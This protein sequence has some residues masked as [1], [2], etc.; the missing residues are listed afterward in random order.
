M[1][2]DEFESNQWDNNIKLV[3]SFNHISHVPI[4]TDDCYSHP[5]D[6]V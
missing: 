1:E 5:Q 6:R 4:D 2:Y 3:N